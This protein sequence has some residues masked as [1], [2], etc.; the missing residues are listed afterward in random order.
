MPPSYTA[1]WVP[2]ANA[3][4]A[5]TARRREPER[6][7]ARLVAAAA[8]SSRASAPLDDRFRD[9]MLVVLRAFLAVPELTAF[10]FHAVSSE[11]LWRLESRLR[12]DRLCREH[13]EITRQPVRAPVVIVGLP[14][15]GTTTLHTRLGAQPALRAPRMWE[16]LAPCPDL[17]RDAASDR[18]E[19]RRRGVAMGTMAHAI[20]P[21][22][23]DAHPVTPDSPEE[24]TFL[25]PH[26]LA[27][28]L[29]VPVPD[30]CHWFGD[31]DATGDYSYM[32]TQ[33]QILQWR[34]PGRRW[35]LKSPFHLWNLPA[36]LT[37]FPD[38]TLVWCH[39]DPVEVLP[40]WCS[41]AER[42]HAV[43]LREVD[44]RA[45]GRDWTRR[46]ASAAAR[47]QSAREVIPTGQVIDVD[48]RDLAAD[49]TGVVRDVL[50]RLCVAQTAR[51]RDVV[52]PAQRT[53]PRRRHTYDASR[54]GLVPAAVR[55]RF[56]SSAVEDPGSR[57]PLVG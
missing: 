31:R 44:P 9:E 32:R 52:L 25:L 5:L 45:L 18:A 37:A 27:Y 30:Y 40:S 35:V 55:A 48:F 17:A 54:Y 23:A 14:R 42:L 13:P 28:H 20:S 19:R 34:D 12:V 22:L 11:L 1:R 15:S 29:R 6:V 36:L 21:G 16:M 33:L 4:L 38:A 39:R 26:S 41:L 56:D 53:P 43:Y 49:T 50:T 8:R 51:G 46:W 24:C 3:A 2:A 10:G 57:S 47:A 7:M